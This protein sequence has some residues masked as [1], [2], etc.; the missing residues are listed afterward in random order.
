MSFRHPDTPQRP[1]DE[2]ELPAIA[3]MDHPHGVPVSSDRGSGNDIDSNQVM[4]APPYW[5][6][7]HTRSTSTV[8]SQSL[9]DTRPTAILLEDH[10]EEDSETSRSCWA[11][12]VFIDEYVIVSGPTG[13]GAY[14]VWQCTV[15]TLKGGDL[16]LRKRLLY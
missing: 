10:S 9:T 11:Q 3:T 8:S 14:V 16:G 6:A 5:T 2:D 4:D 13:I 12:S 1:V 7:Q 15:S